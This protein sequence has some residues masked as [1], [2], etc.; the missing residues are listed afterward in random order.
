MST[1]YTLLSY[2][3]LVTR[4]ASWEDCFKEI[5]PADA[6]RSADLLAT[7]PAAAAYIRSLGGEIPCVRDD[8]ESEPVNVLEARGSS[9]CPTRCAG[10]YAPSIL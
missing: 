7:K 1:R 8:L 4:P 3:I 6:T 2:W 9:G 5:N 10:K